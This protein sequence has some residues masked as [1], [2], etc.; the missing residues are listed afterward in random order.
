MEE[1]LY[2][3][4]FY[5][6]ESHLETVK[7]ALFSAG[8]GRV[9]EYAKCA[10]QTRGT[11]QFQPGEASSPFIGSVGEL[12]KVDEFKVELV[13]VEAHLGSALAALKKA[14]PYEEPAYAVLKLENYSP[15]IS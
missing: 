15:A 13:C 6:P 3:I 14:H 7:E 9:G 4:E 1:Q 12:E 5:V 2:R 10:W 8:A 11:G